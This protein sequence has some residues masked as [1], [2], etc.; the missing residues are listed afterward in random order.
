MALGFRQESDGDSCYLG[1][2]RNVGAQLLVMSDKKR[3]RIPLNCSNCRR[4]KVK[5]DKQRPACGGC[6]RN[7]VGHLC[8]YDVPLW[9]DTDNQK[10]LPKDN[11]QLIIEAQKR[12]IESLQRQLQLQVK[13]TAVNEA[14]GFDDSK[15]EV[16]YRLNDVTSDPLVISKDMVIHVTK[17]PQP[18]KSV[19]DVYSWVSVIKLDPTLS[20]LWS[21]IHTMQKMYYLYKSSKTDEDK[22]P[23]VKY[24]LTLMNDNA[25]EKLEF[26]TVDV[27]IYTYLS[28]IVQN[29]NGAQIKFLLDT[30]FSNPHP[31]VDIFKDKVYASYE[32]NETK[33]SLLFKRNDQT[34]NLCV[35]LVLIVKE[36]LEKFKRRVNEVSNSEL[37]DYRRLFR[38][39]YE[40]DS[41]SKLAL[42][43]EQFYTTKL[44]VDSSLSIISCILM[45][46]N[47]AIRTQYS[48]PNNGTVEDLYGILFKMIFDDGELEIWK[49]PLKLQIDADIS[50]IKLDGIRIH[51]CYVWNEIIR[52]VNLLTLSM[53][54]I[55]INYDLDVMIRKAYNRIEL[56][57]LTDYHQQYLYTIKHH[58]T[59]SVSLMVNNLVAKINMFLS[60]SID[61]SQGQTW[62][63]KDLDVLSNECSDWLQDARL[64]LLSLPQ[65]LE[66]KVMLHFV[67]ILVT[68]IIFLQAESN[69]SYELRDDLLIGLFARLNMFLNFSKAMLD[70]YLVFGLC[71]VFIVI[72]QI[73]VAILIRVN[74]QPYDLFKQL[75]T[76]YYATGSLHKRQ[77]NLKDL[78]RV[79]VYDKI[80]H[81]LN[82]LDGL[83]ITNRIH[84]SKLRQLWNFYETLIDRQ[85][86]SKVSV[87]GFETKDLEKCP[88]D[89]TKDPTDQK[90]NTIDFTKLSAIHS[91]LNH[92]VPENFDEF[93]TNDFD[94]ELQLNFSS[95]GN[96]DLDFLQSYEP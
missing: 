42:Y 82:S 76:I 69:N 55:S 37:S 33:V 14:S 25:V 95:F 50:D 38:D 94:K 96:L 36:T 61:Y 53:V 9:A 66:S 6:V 17:K 47:W 29:L 80:S 93:L 19:R 44:N 8:E 48:R 65:R 83:D 4:R 54:P 46:L 32:I 43:L 15:I 90:P 22:C 70:Q 89:H 30:Y 84:I 74:Q 73:A 51:L 88:I 28:H 78:L 45:T 72:V 52:H 21:K 56:T 85:V 40:E 63:V 1:H 34:D 35:L 7:H 41:F 3:A 10:P 5:C 62:T 31:L 71:E 67:D 49:N 81:C 92:D 59:L 86:D 26:K 24:D 87:I 64:E 77:K 13:Q 20:A 23:V 79:Q 75:S 2:Q 68:Y 57:M 91:N 12:E 39:S 11:Q 18:V 60:R 16:L 58:D 27:D